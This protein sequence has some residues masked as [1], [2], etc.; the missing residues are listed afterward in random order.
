MGSD[1][2][3][4]IH[5]PSWRAAIRAVSAGEL[6]EFS[7]DF[8]PRADGFNGQQLTGHTPIVS[9]AP[10]DTPGTERL[11]K[12][13]HS[14]EHAASLIKQVRL[15]FGGI[16]RQHC[17]KPRHNFS[18]HGRVCMGGEHRDDAIENAFY[19]TSTPHRWSTPARRPDP[20]SDTKRCMGRAFWLEYLHLA[21]TA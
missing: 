7:A 4:G 14:A 15:D 5:C 17:R 16:G 3:T 19:Q 9:R 6:D 1:R 21:V 10:L 20:D 2:P 11:D 8:P 12:P 13:R 18:K